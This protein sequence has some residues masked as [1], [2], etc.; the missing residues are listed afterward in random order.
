MS[1]KFLS[2]G[3]RMPRNANQ[4]KST[5][6]SLDFIPNDVINVSGFSTALSNVNNGTRSSDNNLPFSWSVWFKSRNSSNSQGEIA[7]YG[8]SQRNGIRIHNNVFR[9]NYTSDLAG[10]TTISQNIWYHGVVTYDGTTRK[11]YINGVFDGASDTPASAAISSQSLTIGVYPGGASSFNGELNELCYFDYALSESQVTTLYGTGSAIGNPMALPSTPIAYYPLGTSAWNG[12]YLAE[13]NAIGDYVFDF[14]GTSSQEI[15]LTT[16]NLPSA[17]SSFSMSVWLN[18]DS[19]VPSYAGVLSFGDLGSTNVLSMAYI[20]FDTSNNIKYGFYNGDAG[21]TAISANNWHHVV[22]TYNGTNATF[23]INGQVV[24]IPTQPGTLAI[25][26]TSTLKI[27]GLNT[28][29][30]TFNGKISNAQIFNAVLSGPEVE[31]LYNY[32]SPIQTLASIP[33]SSNLKAWYKLD[34]TEIYNS[35]STEWSV[36]NNQNPSAYPSSLYFDGNDYIDCGATVQQPT[37]NYSVSCWVKFTTIASAST[38]IVGN[39]QGSIVP[40]RGYA[41][42]HQNGTPF[43]FWADGT[44]SSNAARVQGITNPVANVWYNIVGTYDGANVKIYVNNVLENTVS[45]S[46]TPATTNQNLKIGRWYGN[47][48]DYY[49]NGS[50]SNVSI[51]NAALTDGT[52]GTLNQIETLYNNGTPLADMSSFSSLVSWWKLNNTTTGIEDSKGSNNGTNNGAT[53][54]AGF[55]N[56]LAGDSTGMSQSN[57]VQS[58]LQTVAPYS[59]Y[60]L[61]FD[62][63]NDYI[64]CGDVPL[65]GV[66]TISFWINPAAAPIAGSLYFL[67]DKGDGGSDI[68]ARVSQSSNNTVRFQIGSTNFSSTDTLTNNSW[69][70]VILIANGS[71]SKIYINN[72][73]ATTDTLAT[74][75]NTTE[76]FFIAT[77]NSQQSAYFFNGKL[78]NVSIWNT[79]LTPSQVREIY[80]EGLPSNLN[81]FSGTAPVAWW[82]LGSNSSWNGNR[83]IVADEKGT[84][85]GYSQ[86]MAPYM[87]E[88]GLTNG[89]GT[90]ANGTSTGMSEGSLVG[91]APYSTANAISSGMPVTARGTNVPGYVPPTVTVD[92]LVIAGGGG[93]GADNGSGWGGGG[94]A[95]GYRN[96]YNNETSGGNSASETALSVPTSN[97]ITVTVGEGG[98]GVSPNGTGEDSVFST[99]TSIGGGGGGQPAPRDGEDGGSGGGAAN[100]GNGG[101]G[102]SNQGLDGAAGVGGATS[103]GGGGASQT[104]SAPNGGDGLSSSITGT[105]ITRAG[106]GGGTDFGGSY[107]SGNGGAGGGGTGGRTAA[108]RPGATNTGSGGGGGIPTGNNGGDGGSG[109][110]ILRYPSSNT[111]TVGAGLTASTSTIGGDKVTIFTAGT[112]SISIA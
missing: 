47:I 92:F 67:L 9:S 93:G 46:A 98:S 106:G 65:E 33:Q 5:N 101:S 39:F 23:Y 110:V 96:S 6:Y 41:I 81:T 49:T 8:Q 74:A 34:A 28:S 35:T 87:P 3:W 24:G 85:N 88:S 76:S 99:I 10:T 79:A 36:D 48:D 82:Q 45:Y 68:S 73:T 11:I 66:Y 71:S 62:G 84:N 55:V 17:N 38:G 44:A 40:Q 64:D 91:D 30:Q 42:T 21:N 112:G 13:N 95:G 70:N 97:N 51:W 32:G 72:G 26:T 102:T 25:P 90:T 12:Q 61:S 2:P 56:T 108:T 77:D 15:S 29:A 107:P 18:R 50:I 4:S 59:K 89:V 109:I 60:A 54:Y 105:A 1:T 37:T 83:W 94:G 20:N 14:V 7:G 53:E 104:G 52:G 43:Q 100:S 31:T 57:L 111:I 86:N 69:N 16:S 58:N 103:G 19:T 63:T 22:L 80:N 75:P 27:G 78:S